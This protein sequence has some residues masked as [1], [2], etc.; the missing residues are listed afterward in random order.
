MRIEEVKV[1]T[2]DE[3]SE[4][5]KEKARYWYREGGLDYEWW[6]FSFEEFR[7]ELLDIGVETDTFWFALPPD[8]A[9]FLIANRPSIVDP[10]KLLKAS[11]VDLRTKAARAVLNYE[12]D[13]S[14]GTNQYGSGSH[15][16]HYVEADDDDIAE[17]V[18]EFFTDKLHNFKKRL[19]DEQDYLYSDESIDESI[20]INEYEFTEDGER[21]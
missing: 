12:A 3:L 20:R 2:F 21:Y 7:N 18:E 8:R 14:I 10:K 11:G 16:S 6:D 19:E 15:Q 9:D 4:D 1:F 5:A 13:L 17:K